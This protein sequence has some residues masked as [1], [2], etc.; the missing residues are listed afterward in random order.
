MVRVQAKEIIDVDVFYLCFQISTNFLGLNHL[1]MLHI[2]ISEQAF[3]QR[4]PQDQ[5]TQKNSSNE[6]ASASAYNH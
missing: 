4:K 5:D 3:L 1:Q 2:Q 6:T